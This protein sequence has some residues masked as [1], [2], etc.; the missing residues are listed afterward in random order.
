[1]NRTLRKQLLKAANQKGL[2]D[3]GK[4][5]IRHA[6]DLDTVLKQYHDHIG[7]HIEHDNPPEE[8]LREHFTGFYNDWAAVGAK[9]VGFIDQEKVFLA[10]DAE[11]EAHYTDGK[12]GRVFLRHN[13]EVTVYAEP[14][15]FVLV[16]A[17]DNAAVRIRPA[18]TAR[19]YVYLHGNAKVI[20]TPDFPKQITIKYTR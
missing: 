5:I 15:T 20:D 3:A 4:D 7:W 9:N 2:C 16:S 10:L 17:Y 18:D 12:R 11:G 14:K 6:E 8:V 13:A 1:M 19:V